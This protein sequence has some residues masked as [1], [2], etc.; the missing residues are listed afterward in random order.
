VSAGITVGDIGPKMALNS[1]DNG[2]L[3]LKNVRIPRDNMFMRNAE[4]R[5]MSF[6]LSLV[7]VFCAVINAFVR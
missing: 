6:L 3:I 4:V 1:I 5:A 2:F 7:L